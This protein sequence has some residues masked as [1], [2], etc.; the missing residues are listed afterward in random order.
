[1]TISTLHFLSAK[2][3]K[4]QLT[5]PVHFRTPPQSPVKQLPLPLSS[6]VQFVLPQIRPFQ[7]VSTVRFCDL[8]FASSNP[9]SLGPVP[10][11]VLIAGQIM[12][13]QRFVTIRSTIAARAAVTKYAARMMVDNILNDALFLKRMSWKKF[14]ASTYNLVNPHEARSFLQ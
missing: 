1:M 13:L 11:C 8:P 10:P 6:K 2:V 5:V 7:S 4:A 12:S 14:K 9:D 3:A